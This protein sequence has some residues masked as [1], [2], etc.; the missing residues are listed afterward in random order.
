MWDTGLLVKVCELAFNGYLHV[1]AH[2]HTHTGLLLPIRLAGGDNDSSGRVE[3]YH[4]GTWGTIC[5]DFWDIRDARVVCRELGFE[6]AYSAPAFAHFGQ[7]EGERVC[8]CMG[9]H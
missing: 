1:F 8:V 5:D 4:N 3:V 2:T 7:G 6:D 9:R